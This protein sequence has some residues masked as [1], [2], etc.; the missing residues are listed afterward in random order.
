MIGGLFLI[1]KDDFVLIDP[2][3]S[4]TWSGITPGITLE[5]EVIKSLGKPDRVEE[6]NDYTIYIYDQHM[7]LKWKYVEVWLNKGQLE[8]SVLGILL[9]IP[10]DTNQTSEFSYEYL[11][12][13]Y[14]KPDFIAWGTHPYQRFLAWTSR[15]KAIEVTF[16]FMNPFTGSP[17]KP[18]TT[19]QSVFLYKPIPLF[20]FKAMNWPLPG[21]VGWS[22]TNLFVEGVSDTPDN[23]PL[24]PFN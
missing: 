12:K 10:Y 8:K 13:E 6:R 15:G 24:D 5:K 19:L 21:Y 7:N 14:K 9:S 22:S 4:P 3:I 17:I 20:N 18:D 11:A 16:K 23:F 1:F 2:G